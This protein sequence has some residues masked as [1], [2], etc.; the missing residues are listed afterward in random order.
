MSTHSFVSRLPLR[1][2]RWSATHPWRAIGAWF[3]FVLVAVGLAFLVPTQ[4]TTDADYRI[5]QSGRADAMV[6]AG[7]FP[8]GQ[9]ESVVVTTPGGGA[10]APGEARSVAHDLTGA[11]TGLRGVVRVARPQWNAGRTAMLVDV[12]LRKSVADATPVQQAV[13]RVAARHPGVSVREAGNLSVNAA[14]NERV[15]DS[16]SGIRVV[17]QV[18]PGYWEQEGYDVDGWVGRSNGRS[19]QPI[20]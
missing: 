7:R 15:E 1:A 4:Q 16:L 12:H 2:A 17:N 10:L 19:D 6:A 20:G 14:I 11:T 18:E 9:V 3:A 13:A 8:G 5:G